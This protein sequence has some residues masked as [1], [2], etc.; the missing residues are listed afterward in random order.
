MLNLT[1]FKTVFKIC[2]ASNALADLMEGC[3]AHAP[4]LLVQILSI[5]CSF[6]TNSTKSC[7]GTPSLHQGIPGSATVLVGNFTVITDLIA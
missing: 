7:V 6:G 2:N 4:H 3:E 1:I 5:S